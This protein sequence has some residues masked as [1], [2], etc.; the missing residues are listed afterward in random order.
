MPE[1]SKKRVLIVDDAVVVR[2]TL[3]DAVSRDSAFEVVGTAVDRQADHAATFVAPA[4]GVPRQGRLI[5]IPLSVSE[6]SLIETP[7]N[8]RS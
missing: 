5:G 6:L 2:K 7:V 4:R 8:V 3:A 1:L